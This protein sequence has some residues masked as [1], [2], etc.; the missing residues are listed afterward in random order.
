MFAIVMYLCKKGVT[1]EAIVGVVDWR[2]ASM[3]RVVDGVVGPED[4]IRAATEE[5]NQCGKSF[6]VRRYYLGDGE[7]IVS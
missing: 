2:K 7:L 1:P 4:F 6:D 3:F 5:A